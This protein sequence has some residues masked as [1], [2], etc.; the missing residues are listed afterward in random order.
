MEDIAEEP[1]VD[2]DGCDKRN[3]LAVVEY[4]D[5]LYRNYKKAEVI[6]ELLSNCFICALEDLVS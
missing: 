2:I 1:V 5:D 6:Y 4:I 3:P